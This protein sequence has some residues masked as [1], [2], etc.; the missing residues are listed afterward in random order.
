MNLFTQGMITRDGAKMS[1]SKGNTVSPREYIER[2]GADAA[3]T[4]ICFMGPPERGGDWVDEGIEGV[5]RFLSRLWRLADEVTSRTQPSD[6]DPTG[7]LVAVAHE[8]IDK[9]T[10]DMGAFQFHTA[11]SAVMELINEAYKV[12]DE[13]YGDPAGEQALRFATATAASLIFPFAPHLSSELYESL[14]GERVWEQPWPVADASLLEHET[15]TLVIQVNG[16]RRDQA[17]ARTGA[18]KEELLELAYASENV[19]RHLDGKEVV[20]EIVVPDK[21]VNLVVR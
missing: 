6:L 18:S 7:P 12:K 14:V 17:E 16:K 1:K 8:K 5:H 11:I 19:R 20:K 15:F 13:L 3:R 2:Y 21:L 10:R 4:Y 9:A